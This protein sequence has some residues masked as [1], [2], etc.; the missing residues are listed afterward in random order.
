MKRCWPR[1]GRQPGLASVDWPQCVHVLL[2]MLAC[3]WP[4]GPTVHVKD[5]AVV[6]PGAAYDS[7]R[8]SP[9]DPAA[10]TA[11]PA[12]S[13]GMCACTRTHPHTKCQL[14]APRPPFFNAGT[15]RWRPGRFATLQ[16]ARPGTAARQ[17][18]LAAAR[19]CSFGP[20]LFHGGGR[21][22]AAEAPD[23]RVEVGLYWQR[24]G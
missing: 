10:V 14:C 19:L 9:G 17:H 5:V 15:H 13:R 16:P 3:S 4:A 23:G 20:C 18:S 1:C 7:V 8:T 12:C 2:G 6:A 21:R 11:I 22:Q 24:W